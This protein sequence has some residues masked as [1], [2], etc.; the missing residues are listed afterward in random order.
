M[1]IST[2]LQSRRHNRQLLDKIGEEVIQPAIDKF[3]ERVDR[4]LKADWDMSAKYQSITIHF[5]MQDGGDMSDEAI[6]EITFGTIADVVS[7]W[8]AAEADEDDCRDTYFSVD[9]GL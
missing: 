5:E 9:I 7:E 6:G 3:N 4:P 8:F 2:Y 1:E